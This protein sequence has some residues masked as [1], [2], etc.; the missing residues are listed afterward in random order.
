MNLWLIIKLKKGNKMFTNYADS[1]N[2]GITM[3][4]SAKKAW[5][6]SF[7]KDETIAKALTAFVD[8]QTDFAKQVVK[9]NSDVATVIS[10][11]IGKWPSYGK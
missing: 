10:K 3:V 4:Q 5:V 7:V 9:T 8:A 1:A 11:E 6:S 2:Y